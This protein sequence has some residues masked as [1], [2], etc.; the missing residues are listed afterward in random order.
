MGEAC[1]FGDDSLNPEG[2]LRTFSTK[3]PDRDC[4]GRI[5]SPSRSDRAVGHTRS[6]GQPGSAPFPDTSARMA[7]CSGSPEVPR[8]A[9]G[10][11]AGPR[12]RAGRH[13]VRGRRPAVVAAATVRAVAASRLFHVL[14]LSVHQIPRAAR[15]GI[16]GHPPG[17][18]HS[19]QNLRMDRGG[20]SLVTPG[21]PPW[22]TPGRALLR[23]TSGLPVSCHAPR[24][25]R[26]RTRLPQA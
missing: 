11:G 10:S 6:F 9:A 7:G 18:T 2:R 21:T 4:R 12:G 19:D 23:G 26:H 22:R 24:E 16:P 1:D 20:D 17:G 25:T 14:D 15:C 8:R 13:R 3:A 5:G